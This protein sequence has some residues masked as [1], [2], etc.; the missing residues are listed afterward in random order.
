LQEGK[1]STKALPKLLSEMK[2]RSRVIVETSAE[3]FRIADAALAAE[4]EVRVV[5]ATLV[6]QLGV[7]SR[8]VKND[9]KDARILSE[10]SCRI[11]LPSVHVPSTRS[12][13][14]KSICGSREALIH[15][16]TMLINNVRGWQRAQLIRIRTGATHSFPQRLR[17]HA[18]T[19]KLTLPEHVE[20][21][22]LAIEMLNVQVKA[23]DQ[24]LKKIADACAVCRRLMTTPG[25]GPVTAVRFVAAIDDAKRFK[26]AHAVGSY[27]GLTPGENSSSERT[28]KLG[29]TKAGANEL[30]RSLVQAAWVVMY[31]TKDPMAAWAKQ[32]EARRGKFIAVVALARK[33]SGILFALWRDETS[34]HPSKS[35]ATKREQLHA[36]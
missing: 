22:L 5:P 13:E 6:K 11:L 3:S 34:Y 19:N 27:V 1:V 30:R 23:A 7:G 8:G 29:I 31:R 35:A 2:E 21:G 24:Q 16:R 18:E 14:L 20:R 25:I 15:S 36:A 12:R 26:S 17:E 10:A 28:Q 4:H 9:R 32:I 33:L